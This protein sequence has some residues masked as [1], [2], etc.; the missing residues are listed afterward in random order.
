MLRVVPLRRRRVPMIWWRIVTVGVRNWRVS[1]R[2]HVGSEVA[3]PSGRVYRARRRDMRTRHHDAG[4]VFLPSTVGG[5]VT[6]RPHN[7]Q[8]KQRR[9]SSRGAQEH[10]LRAGYP[11]DLGRCEEVKREGERSEE[12]RS[13]TGRY[14]RYVDISG[15][16]VLEP[17]GTARAE[18]S[19]NGRRESIARAERE[20]GD[21]VQAK[22][23]PPRLR[24]VEGGG[25]A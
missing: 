2:R 5:E 23:R 12:Q 3:L 14:R 24:V 6:R 19:C 25:D 1:L 22:G 20:A 10:L 9:G 17:C 16:R 18:E 15:S 21:V 11:I 4:A 7:Q 8:R 13:L